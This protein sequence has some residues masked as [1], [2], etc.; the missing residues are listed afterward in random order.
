MRAPSWAGG[1]LLAAW[2]AGPALAEAPIPVERL[3]AIEAFVRAAERG[4]LA[5]V[6]AGLAAGM[7]VDVTLP[8][9]DPRYPYTVRTALEAAASYG[10]IDVVRLLLARGAV[11]RR[12]ERYGVYAAALHMGDVPELLT[13]LIAA[14]GPD[15]DLDADFGPALVRAAA[16]GAGREVDTL[17]TIGV[18][19]DFRS[20]YEP[21]DDPAIVRAGTHLDIVDRLLEAGA[22]PTGGD[23][24]Y[25]W[26][27]LFPAALAADAERTRRFLAM[28]ID[29]QLRGPYGN[30]LSLVACRWPR[31]S[32]PSSEVMQRT[33][34]VVD[35]LLEAGVDP[36]VAYDGRTPLRCAEDAQDATLAAM[37][38]AAGGRSH[39][40]LWRVVKRGAIKLGLGIALLLGGRM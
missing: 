25:G 7:P 28:G 14:A 5:A 30:A 12:D 15:P 1:L 18:D 32:R 21:W 37:L 24:A 35:L 16:N 9:K 34:G 17:L 13:L 27:P 8:P 22:D 23:L 36:N 39:E 40:S 19:P 11:L 26:S 10:R 29:P 4:D 20:R 33:H 2:I 3:T 31:T 38:T 6:E